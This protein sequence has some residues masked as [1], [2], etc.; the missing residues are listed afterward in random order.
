MSGTERTPP[1]TVKGMVSASATR[2][3]VLSAV[4][5]ASQVAVM[6]RRHS[7]SASAASYAT[8]HSTGS[9]SSVRSLKRTP[10]TTRPFFTSRQGM[11]RRA[12]TGRF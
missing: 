5:R 11:I 6:S 7:S 3:T 9:P 2:R 4:P 10:L 12:S 1:P 8:A